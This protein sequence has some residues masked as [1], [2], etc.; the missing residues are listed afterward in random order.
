VFLES[1]DG[2]IMA[3]KFD[4]YSEWLGIKETQRPLT[5][6]Q[7]LGLLPYESR[8]DVI[9]ENARKQ[10][11]RLAVVSK[12]DQAMLA[13][14]VAFEVESAKTCLLNSATKAAYDDGLRPR[15]ATAAKDESAKPA[16][17]LIIE[18]Q[19]EKHPLKGRDPGR[20]PA[21]HALSGRATRAISTLTVDSQP[22]L[23]RPPVA[24][25]ADQKAT[26]KVAISRE[27][28]PPRRGPPAS[29]RPPAAPIVDSSAGFRPTAVSSSI[30][31]A[32]S[33]KKPRSHSKTRDASRRNSRRAWL[34][35]AAAGGCVM[36]VA[37][38]LMAQRPPADEKKA[39]PRAA[40]QKGAYA[41]VPTSSVPA[42]PVATAPPQP[43][44]GQSP[45][46]ARPAMLPPDSTRQPD[47]KPTQSP[48]VPGNVPKR[49]SDRPHAGPARDG[50][51]NNRI[52]PVPH[53]Q[54]IRPISIR[55]AS[56]AALTESMLSIPTGWQQSLFPQGIAPFVDTYPNDAVRG[57]FTLKKGLL[58]GWAATLY[59]NGRLQTLALYKD[60]RLH[61]PLRQ[62]SKNGERILYADY[63]CGRKDG[64]L[65]F[66]QK[67]K[68]RLI[69]EWTTGR[70]QSESLVKWKQGSPYALPKA[71]FTENDIAESSRASEEL[72]E[73]EEMLR[74]DETQLKQKLVKLYEKTHAR[75]KQK[76]ASQGAAGKQ[77]AQ[78]N[79]IPAD[80][81]PRAAESEAFWRGALRNAGF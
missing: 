44:S 76:R 45:T 57:V 81:A 72:D 69:Q 15:E 80:N 61:G 1:Q 20:L 38:M 13:K 78:R 35:A 27:T 12:G 28:A 47:T 9:E 10:Q 42:K 54:M 77:A 11:A 56:G 79:R 17:T 14:R 8:V 43:N 64:L 30:R 32:D 6:Y 48:D 19:V 41:F 73:L 53:N 23:P 60:A 49:N 7:L 62:W 67:G 18:S 40:Q 21:A 16:K 2:K 22:S 25:F 26:A 36:A 33:V 58:H 46:A 24:N 68:P 4:P 5:N 34:T 52:A 50:A 74:Q 31:P 3:D 59:D 70:V 65:C 63:K 71:Q 37:V 66:F 51:A 55:L 29:A 75:T 39:V